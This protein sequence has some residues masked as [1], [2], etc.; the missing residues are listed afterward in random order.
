VLGK[1]LEAG[2]HPSR[3]STVRG[4]KVVAHRRFEVVAESGGRRELWWGSAAVGGRGESE[5]TSRRREKR[6]RAALIGDGEDS[7]GAVAMLL[8]SACSG[9]D[10]WMRGGK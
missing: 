8:V 6:S 10:S 9:S 3:L 5:G 2:S 7:A 1:A 4:E